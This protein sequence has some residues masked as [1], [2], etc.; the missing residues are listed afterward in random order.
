[1]APTAFGVQEWDSPRSHQCFRL[2]WFLSP[3][4][5]IGSAGKEALLGVGEG[6]S[7]FTR[8]PEFSP[9]SP[10]VDGQQRTSR[11]RDVK[12]IYFFGRVD[13]GLYTNLKPIARQ[14]DK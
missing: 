1:M 11:S 5:E 4:A 8:N 10:D 7:P 14:G 9:T 2:S 3:N 13:G 12:N 6:G